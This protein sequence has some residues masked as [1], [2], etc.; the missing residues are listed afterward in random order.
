MGRKQT[1]NLRQKQ[2]NT[3]AM[4]RTINGKK[5]DIWL[6]AEIKKYSCN[7]KNNRMERKETFKAEIK[8]YQ[9]IEKDK[10]SR[11]KTIACGC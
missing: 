3:D 2:I 9:C 11:T 6:K 4:R 1:F 7:E 5:R 10:G 8:K